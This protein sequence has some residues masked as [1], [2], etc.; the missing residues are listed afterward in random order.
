MMREVNMKF[1]LV[2]IRNGGPAFGQSFTK[3]FIAKF[4]S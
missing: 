4:K 1:H 3:V 2:L